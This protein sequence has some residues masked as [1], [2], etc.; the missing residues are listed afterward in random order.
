M[1]NR[2]W[3]ISGDGVAGLS[4]ACFYSVTASVLA[5]LWDV[6]DEPIKAENRPPGVHGRMLIH[7]STAD[8]GVGGLA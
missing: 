1:P 5:T 6:A 8:I 4:R 7:K 2:T 3:K